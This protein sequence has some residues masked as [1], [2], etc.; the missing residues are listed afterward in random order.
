MKKVIL[1][2]SGILVAAF[3]IVFVANAANGTQ[4]VKKATTEVSKDC[5]KCPSAA[6]CEKKDA[7]STDAASCAA[8]CKEAGMDHANCK[9]AAACKEKMEGTACAKK[10]EGMAGCKMA[11]KK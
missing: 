10:C 7:K 8:K 1:A 3:V 2:L 5:S 4:E 11:E 9:E 6:A